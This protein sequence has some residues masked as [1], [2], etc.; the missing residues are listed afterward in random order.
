[1]ANADY[2]YA[3]VLSGQATWSEAGSDGRASSGISTLQNRL[4]QIG[5]L[6]TPTGL[7]N[8]TTTT[9]VKNFQYSQGLTQNGTVDSTVLTQLDAVYTI[10]FFEYGKPLS[11]AQWGTTKILSGAFND[12]DLLARI[13]YAENTNIFLDQNGVAIVIKKRSETPGYY[14]PSSG[15]TASIWARVVGMPNQYSTAN[16]GS[17]NARQPR[18]GFG[19][20]G[21]NGYVAPGWRHAVD[22]AKKLVHGTVINTTGNI[23]SGTTVTSNKKSI[24][25]TDSTKY[26]N[27]IAW[28]Q[29]KS[30]Y[31]LGKIDTTVEPLCFTSTGTGS[32]V[33][34]KSK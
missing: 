12:I 6:V 5:Y 9:A 20:T 28:S 25:S 27:Q 18:R 10:D 34:C 15:S 29:Y 19:G 21:G 13:I 26:L 4:S 24:S 23:I 1:M 31:S 30:W 8:S 2:T 22:V 14:V 33:I 3:Q 17:I 16:A 32:N 7:F 11:E